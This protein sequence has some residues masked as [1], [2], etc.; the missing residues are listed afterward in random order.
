[1]SYPYDE[2]PYDTTPAPVW[3][4]TN[5]SIIRCSWAIFLIQ[6]SD[7][8]DMGRLVA[9]KSAS[10]EGY[11]QRQDDAQDDRGRQREIE[12]EVAAPHDDV[13]REAAERDAEHHDQSQAR[14]AQPDQH[15][16]STQGSKVTSPVSAV[17]PDRRLRKNSRSRTPP[18]PAHP[19]RASRCAR[20]TRQT[21]CAACRVR[22]SPDRW[23]P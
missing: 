13:A 1:M 20:W 17:A 8:M 22:P 23:R 3:L 16:R 5:G 15:E 18:S 21:P 7:L 4:S 6:R 11:Q 9:A 19:T 14:D 12:G 2:T 10:E